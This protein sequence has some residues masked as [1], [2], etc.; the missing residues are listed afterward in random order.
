MA[1]HLVDNLNIDIDSRSLTNPGNDS[2]GNWITVRGRKSKVRKRLRRAGTGA[3]HQISPVTVLKRKLP[4]AV[5]I[6]I[7]C[8]SNSSC[9]E[10][11]KKAKDI[12]INEL[13]ID[14]MN[15]KRAITG[16]LILELSGKNLDNKANLPVKK[17]RSVFIVR[18]YI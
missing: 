14:Y 5:A 13:G 7:T 16:G 17:L 1:S 3:E 18:S 12:S 15:P 11:L 2:E 6:C 10:T 9:A 4:R 8:G